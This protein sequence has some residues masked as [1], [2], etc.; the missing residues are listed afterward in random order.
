MAEG[1]RLQKKIDAENISII[2]K[3]KKKW[4]NIL[5]KLLD[6]TL[7]LA[8]QNLTFHGHKENE[9]S[10]NRENFLKI[11]EMFSKRDPLLKEHLT[12]LKRNACTVKASVSYLLSETQNEFINVLANH[13]EKILVMD[14]KAAK[15]FGIMFDSASDISHTDQMYEVIRYVKIC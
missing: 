3:E 12:R 10:L 2:D 7:F 13:E 9:F 1:L 8:K 11:V 5:H 6:I 4:R 14:I 15:H